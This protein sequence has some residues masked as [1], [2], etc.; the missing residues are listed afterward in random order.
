MVRR[1]GGIRH[2][3]SNGGLARLR[4][5][6]DGENSLLRARIMEATLV[7]SGEKGYRYVTVQDVI[8]RYGG[9]RSQ[10][11][12]HF[13]SKASCY[14]A[15]YEHEIVRRYAELHAEVRGSASLP[16]ALAAILDGIGRFVVRQPMLARGLLL[17][18][19]VAGGP[20]L[21]KRGEILGRLAEAMDAGRLEQRPSLPPL[22][23][24]F[25]VSVIEAALLRALTRRE[26]QEFAATAPEL[27][28]LVSDAYLGDANAARA[29]FELRTA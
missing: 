8:D 18:V 14:A 3:P 7:A 6:G 23:A 25:L 5:E 16:E 9:H 26:P 11:Y 4:E 21:L 13:P 24:T 28:R 12:S 17:E 2:A 1:E 20:A 22:T 19:H 27:V 10:F 29:P 15:A